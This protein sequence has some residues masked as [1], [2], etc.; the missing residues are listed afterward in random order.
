MHTVADRPALG[1]SG[2]PRPSVPA[3]GSSSEDHSGAYTG[4]KSS[5]RETVV[6]GL[7]AALETVQ[8][9]AKIPESV[10]LIEPIG[11]ILS[12]LIEVYKEVGDTY[13]T[14]DALLEKVAT[15]TR[16]ICGL[17]LQ[18]KKYGLIDRF[19][20]LESDLGQYSRL[21]ED[22]QNLVI[23]FDEHGKP[24]RMIKHG[25][26][27]AGMEFLHTKL[28][29]LRKRFKGGAGS[30]NIFGGVGGDGGGGGAHGQGGDGGVGEGNKLTFVI[31][32]VGNLNN[33]YGGKVFHKSF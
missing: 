15:V 30:I 19:G 9:V 21:L 4:N 25:E 26:F 20:D 18:L 11:A 7:S 33:V 31:G 22:A 8:Q 10:H 3:A 16:D 1:I 5:R 6:C 17:I 29:F 24:V 14:R 12:E 28:D 27:R 2:I 23:E 13:D 32:A